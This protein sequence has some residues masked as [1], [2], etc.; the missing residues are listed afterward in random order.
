M[1]ASRRASSSW[2]QIRGSQAA[3]LAVVQREADLL[4]GRDAEPAGCGAAAD[5]KVD[6]C[7]QHRD[8][9][10]AAP[11]DAAADLPQQRPDQPVL[12]PRHV[13]QCQL[14]PAG[15]AADLPE[16]QARRA[17]AQVVAAL[18]GAERESIDDGDR[19][20]AGAEGGLQHHGLVQVAASGLE[21]PG[22]ADG[23]V[24]GLV[25]QQPP[26]HRRAV[27]SREAQPLHRSLPVHQRGRVAVGQQRVI[28]DRREAHDRSPSL[29]TASLGGLPAA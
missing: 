17:A 11:V 3:W 28:S 18:A 22:R 1:S 19:A 23:P 29:R 25:V 2:S 20:R 10:A 27:E 14:H 15:H 6:W 5:L 12:R 7:G 24:P 21:V 26:E 16:Q 13:L 9:R 8:V 4:A